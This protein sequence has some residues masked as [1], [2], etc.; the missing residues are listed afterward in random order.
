MPNPLP[1]NI[2][3]NPRFEKWLN[4]QTGGKV[5]VATGKVEIGQGVTTALSQIAA[6]ELDLTLDQIIMLSGDSD[7]GPN[8][9]YT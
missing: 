1:N 6:E 4:F 7:L 9:S 3:L 5:R 8:A 2:T